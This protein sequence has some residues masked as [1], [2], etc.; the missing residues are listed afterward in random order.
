MSDDIRTDEIV[1]AVA[2]GVSLRA[3]ARSHRM[4]ESEVREIIDAEA[5]CCFQGEQLRRE[6]MPEAKRLSQLGAL[7]FERA[8]QGDADAAII[9]LKAS[10]R[11]ATL[12]SINATQ[13]YSVQII[14]ATAAP[15][16][17]SRAEEIDAIRQREPDGSGASN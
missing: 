11:R 12:C 9:Y 8:M 16:Q 4:T 7:Y 3:V 13:C 15:R 14:H 10:E 2:N 6:W 5:A 17:L 1:T